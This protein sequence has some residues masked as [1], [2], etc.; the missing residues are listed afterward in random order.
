MTTIKL[1]RVQ[2]KFKTHESEF[3]NIKTLLV[4]MKA[5]IKNLSPDKVG[6]PKAQD[7][8]IMIPDN[9]KAQPLEDVN[10]MKIGGMWTLKH[11]INS[12]KI[13]ELLIKT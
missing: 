3:T 12:P 9:K 8:E 2:K 1:L 5:Q 6:S 10:S 4:Q 11:D 7:Y 13:Y